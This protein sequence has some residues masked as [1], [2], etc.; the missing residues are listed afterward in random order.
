MVQ[1]QI[2]LCN[3]VAAEQLTHNVAFH[4]HFLTLTSNDKHSKVR[5]FLSLLI[6]LSLVSSTFILQFCPFHVLLSTSCL[7]VFF[8]SFWFPPY[9]SLPCV[10]KSVSFPLSLFVRLFCFPVSVLDSF[11]SGPVSLRYSV[12][13][14]R[15]LACFFCFCCWLFEGLFKLAITFFIPP[16]SSCLVFGSS[17]WPTTPAADLDGFSPV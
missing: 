14:D 11:F 3:Q 12:Y 4:A 15:P 16:G 13:L 10:F 7:C 17:I 6:V 2:H 5:L 8:P 1:Q 9:S